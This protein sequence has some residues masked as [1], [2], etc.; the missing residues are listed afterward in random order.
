MDIPDLAK[1]MKLSLS[2]KFKNSS[3]KILILF[4]CTNINKHVQFKIT[5]F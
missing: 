4:R 1:I 3:S 2:E 5:P